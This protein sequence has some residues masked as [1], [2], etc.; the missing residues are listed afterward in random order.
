MTARRTLDELSNSMMVRQRFLE[1]ARRELRDG[2][3][4][5]ALHDIVAMLDH[6]QDNERRLLELHAECRGMI[7]L[8]Q[9][10]IASEELRRPMVVTL[11]GGNAPGSDT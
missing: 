10:A 2:F 4:S 7:E 1:S 8:C 3:V 11:N 6:F 9:K 5:E